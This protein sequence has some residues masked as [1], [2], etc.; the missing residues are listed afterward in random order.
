[1]SQIAVLAFLLGL[2]LAVPSF[3][4]AETLKDCEQHHDSQLAIVSCSD[5]IRVQPRHAEHYVSRGKAHLRAGDP[6][7]A[8][9]D[10]SRAIKIDGRSI[11][12]Y[13]L[14]GYSYIK[15][16]DF[17]QAIN[18][19]TAVIKRFPEDVQAYLDRGNAS[20]ALHNSSDDALSDYNKV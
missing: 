7:A 9:A 4:R 20:Y 6:D 1:M 15:K 14:R 17:E 11:G 10:A 18:A 2:V 12:A 19:F 5:L 3:V 13:R 16:K 8:L